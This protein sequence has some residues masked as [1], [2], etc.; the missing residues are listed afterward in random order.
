MENI[1]SSNF[2]KKYL[3][4]EFQQRIRRNPSYSLRSF[5]RALGIDPSALSRVFNHK[6]SLG[7]Y[8]VQKIV[9]NLS[10]DGEQAHKFIHSSATDQKNF[11]SR[12][13]QKEKKNPLYVSRFQK[14]IP[15]FSE[16][17]FEK[18]IALFDKTYDDLFEQDLLGDGENCTIEVSFHPP[19]GDSIS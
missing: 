17:Q 19:K 12:K 11:Q 9:N 1:Q 5:A 4:D 7:P 10:L 3:W 8:S 16:T 14:N 18:I 15:A 6:A 13:I 2:Y